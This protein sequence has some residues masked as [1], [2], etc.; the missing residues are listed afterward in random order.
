MLGELN[1][2]FGFAKPQISKIDPT[3]VFN[4]ISKIVWGTIYWNKCTFGLH[5]VYTEQYRST[6]SPSRAILGL[7]RVY[8][9]PYQATQNLYRAL[10]SL[11]RAI[12]GL[13]RAKRNYTEST[14]SNSEP[15]RLL[16]LIVVY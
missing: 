7:H 12:Q 6:Q 2:T 9:E 16:L 13:H 14:Q 4:T 11:H 1:P 10:L 5:R 8:T 3:L 15:K